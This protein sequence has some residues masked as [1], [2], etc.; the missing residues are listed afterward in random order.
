MLQI[1]PYNEPL[2]EAARDFNRR[3]DQSG[4]RHFIRLPESATPGMLACDKGTGFFQECFLGVENGAVRGGYI[5]YHQK[6]S[7][8]GE[9]VAV[10][11]AMRPISEGVIE[12]AYSLVGVALIQHALRRE[13]LQFGLGLGGADEAITKM[14]RTMRWEVRPVPMYFR[15]LNGRRFAEEFRPIRARRAL[16]LMADAA[17]RTGLAS[18]AIHAAGLPA[19]WR[20][21]RGIEAE[22]IDHFSGWADELWREAQRAYSVLEW[23]DSVVLNELFAGRPQYFR[24]RVSERGRSMGWAVL[25]Q[26]STTRTKFGGMQV[27]TIL[28][29]LALP[30]DTE[31]VIAAAT[32]FLAA[33]GAD[34]VLSY[35]T[36]PSW[37][38]A[39]RR[40]G[41]YRRPSTFLFAS[42]PELTRRIRAADAALSSVHLTR[43]GGDV[44]VAWG[45]RVKQVQAVSWKES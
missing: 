16:S 45:S 28:D 11:N 14:L 34:L 5:L 36:H 32:R 37:R 24:L 7:I 12:R 43:G 17:V 6:W 9:G 35:Q 33:R 29:C 1:Q 44:P 8:A 41:F 27:Y 40:A 38:R 13:P 23:R 31:A 3:L 20:K 18:A 19:S 21:R 25:D 22:C 10:A 42:A 26:V 39:L 2:V 4:T 30:P 15:V